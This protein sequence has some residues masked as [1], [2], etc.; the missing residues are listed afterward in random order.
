MSYIHSGQTLESTVPFFVGIIG[1]RHLREEEI[2]RLQHE[3]DSHI[4]SLLARLKHTKIVVLTGNAEGADR[5]PQTSQHRNHFSICAALPFSKN[6]YVR[7]FPSKNQRATFEESLSQCDHIVISPHSPTGK[8][9]ATL[10]DKS[11]QESA[12]WISDNSNLLIG[13]WDG[14]EPRGIGGTSDTVSYRVSDISTRKFVHE[15]ES[16][17]IHIKA[18]NGERNFHEN[19]KCA[20]HEIVNAQYEKFLDELDNLNSLIEPSKITPER[21]QLKLFFHQFD[22]GATTLQKRFNR[23]TISIFAC[24]F[25][26]VQFAFIQ[27]QTFSFLW[28]SLSTLAMLVTG[29]QWW[30]LW[31]LRIKSS[32]ETLRFVAEFLRIQIWWDECGLKLNAFNDNVGYHDIRDST[33][34][35]LKNVF[36][37]STISQPEIGLIGKPLEREKSKGAESKWIE[38]QM[39]YLI[40]SEISLGAIKRNR[41]AAKRGLVFALVSLV[42]AGIIQV[43]STVSSWFNVIETGSSLDWA[44]KMV[45]PFLLSIA[46]YVAAYAKL[47]GYKEVKIL[48]ELKLRRLEIGLAQLRSLDP[49]DDS[50]PIVK[51]VGSASL[52][53]SLRWFQLKGDRELRPFQ[54]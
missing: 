10:R 48:Y 49:K 38:D 51:S 50:G 19:C 28:L 26:T 36:L 5:I 18:S 39:K 3:F 15:S 12:R 42:L 13:F 46:A 53:E 29:T 27:Q 47:M 1:H 24:A 14:L 30:S 44:L 9:T 21:N 43:L 35:L 34:S 54:T 6:E 2:P 16:G 4:K 33:Y 40:G 7:D 41:I 45:F 20:G 17:F 37:Y 31:R 11:Y 8:F 52:T 25:L 23:R 22:T 32:Y